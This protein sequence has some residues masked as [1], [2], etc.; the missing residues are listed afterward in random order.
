MSPLLTTDPAALRR[1]RD[2]MRALD[3]F[4][5]YRSPLMARVI[6]HGPEVRWRPSDKTAVRWGWA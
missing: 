2:R 5:A 3:L 6:L 1:Q 4:L